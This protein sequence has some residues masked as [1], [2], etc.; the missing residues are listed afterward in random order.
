MSPSFSAWAW[1]ILKISSCLRRPLAF[2]TFI[3]RAMPD[4]SGIV[5]SFSS[6]RLRPPV[7]TVTAVWAGFSVAALDGPLSRRELMRRLRERR[8]VAAWSLWFVLVLRGIRGVACRQ[9]RYRPIGAGRCQRF[10][11]H[12]DLDDGAL[13]DL[14][15]P[16]R[17]ARLVLLAEEDVAHLLPGPLQR[18]AL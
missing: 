9:Q 10:P 4:S 7:G 6:E 3:S 18:L 11:S 8:A 14:P 15:Q 16:R 12:A 13:L 17:E 5:F 2:W 1:R